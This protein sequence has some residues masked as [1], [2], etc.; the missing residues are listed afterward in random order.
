L[1]AQKR[2]LDRPEFGQYL[3]LWRITH[4]PRVE[5]HAGYHMQQVWTPDGRYLVYTGR[6]IAPVPDAREPYAGVGRPMVHVYDFFRN[7]DRTL[8][9]GIMQG[10]GPVW[11]NHHNWLFYVQTT[12]AD[13]G[14]AGP[15]GSPLVWLDM[16]TGRTVKIGD[17]LDQLGGV[18]CNDQWVYGGIK[19]TS[20]KPPF[21][22]ARVAISPE[23]GVQELQDVTGIQWVPNPRFPMLH[24][25]HDHLDEP[26]G[27]NRWWWDLDGTHR[28]VGQWGLETCHAAWQGNG[29]HLLLGDGLARGRRWNEPAPGNVH[30][31]AAGTAGNLSACGRTGRFAVG[32]SAMF[33]LRSGDAWQYKYFLSPKLKPS[34]GPYPSFDGEARGSPDGTKVH[35]TVA[36]DMEQGPVTEVTEHFRGIE[37]IL[38]VQSTA[39]FADSG[40]IVFWCEVIGYQR[41][42]ATTFEGLDRGRH[43][44]PVSN[45]IPKGRPITDFRFHL[46]S[47]S[48]WKTVKALGHD[49]RVEVPDRASPLFRQRRNALYVAVVRRPD[50]PLLRL[51]EDEVHLIP[52]ESHHETFGY[53][54]ICDGKRITQKPA[55]IGPTESL[56]KSGEYQAVAVE[57]SGLESE[58]GPVLLVDKPAK[59][60][61]LAEP[62]QDFAWT[63]QRW[64]V[65]TTEV[66][67]QQA[68]AAPEATC[69]FMHHADGIIAR[70]W[71]QRGRLVRR[72]DLNAAGQATRRLEYTDGKLATRDYFN[73]EQHHVSRELFAP[74]G[75]ITELVLYNRG[76]NVMP[77]ADHWWYER[78]VPVRRVSFGQ[79]WMKKGERWVQS[80]V[81]PGI[82]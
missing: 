8:G 44:T 52:G 9:L 1:F 2:E 10:F 82:P 11:A 65:N 67:P 47:D 69:E 60:R 68:A 48:Q 50:R 81:S 28:R 15:R 33:D 79:Q 61:V 56:A 14:F 64:L 71:Y 18:D 72:H 37:D 76:N 13:R 41:K 51:V 16:D 32:D 20:R 4:D 19:D 36:Y 7:E 74:D 27:A 40:Q 6:V 58:P 70:E 63:R 43:G 3:A 39:G 49:L 55:R 38:R 54:L 59:L 80:Q 78:G 34:T 42:T 75:F 22:I 5:A 77:E 24:T 53:H 25:R 73:R 46:L 57:W 17:G 66:T 30:V 21:R 31:L 45:M 29:E 26:F 35:F 62:P 12:E 23:G